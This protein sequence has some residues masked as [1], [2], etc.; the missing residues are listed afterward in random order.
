MAYKT[1]NIVI[2]GGGSAGWMTASTFIKAFPEK[3]ITVVESS[4][5]PK[6][7]VGESTVQDFSAWLNYLDIDYKDFM[8]Y[9]NASYKLAIGFTN[10]KTKNSPTFYYPFGSPDLTNTVFGINDWYYKKALNSNI[11]DS[12]YVQYYYPQAHCLDTNK[13]F[14]DEEK[15]FYPNYRADK[16]IVYQFDASLFGDWLA[17]KYAIPKGVKRIIGTLGRINGTE[18]GITSIVLEDGTEVFGDLFIDCTGFRSLLLG[19]YLNEPFISIKDILPNNKAWATQV[20]Y[21]NKEKEL[22]NYTNCTGEKNGW[23]WNIPL[24]NRMGSGYVFSDEFVDDETALQEYKNYLDSDNMVFYDP[25]R[26]KSLDFK[27]IE[28]RNGYHER[29][30]VKNVCAIGLSNGFIEPLESTGLMMIHQFVKDLINT[31]QNR[32]QITRW[33]IDSFNK[34]NINTFKNMANFVAFHFQLSQRDDTPYWKKITMEKKYPNDYFDLSTQV[35]KDREFNSSV[36]SCISAGFGYKPITKGIIQEINFYKDKNVINDLNQSFIIRNKKRQMWK[37]II[38]KAPT[39]YEY[40][41][42][43]IYNEN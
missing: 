38:E 29:F 10:F 43:N 1:D 26:S 16:D 34:N 19:Q 28:I 7:G 12:D 31:I 36:W 6:V 41:K 25:N 21:N 15:V 8:L 32:E 23:I 20:P 5:I 42:K 22:K 14:I 35:Y 33:D 27:K 40:L 18:D 37:E 4:S 3:N 39:H 2:V 30:W 17:N 24:W 11:L 9:T 13:I